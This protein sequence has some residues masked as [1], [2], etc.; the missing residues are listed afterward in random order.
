M[1]LQ[2]TALFNPWF[3]FRPKKR[4]ENSPWDSPTQKTLTLTGLEVFRLVLLNTCL[5]SV[6]GVVCLAP[7]KKMSKKLGVL[8]MVK[9]FCVSSWW[10]GGG[11]LPGGEGLLE[12]FSRRFFSGLRKIKTFH[13]KHVMFL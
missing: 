8:I 2:V 3:F 13:G 1:I 4:L 11:F 9:F 12:I 7:P 5:G 10:L 6:P